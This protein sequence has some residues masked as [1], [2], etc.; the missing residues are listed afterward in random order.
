VGAALA[1]GSLAHRGR[2][3][4]IPVRDLGVRRTVCLY[5]VAGRQRTAAANA[6]LKVLRALPWPVPA[7]A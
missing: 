4:A 2:L 6:A 1:P 5:G 7:A 3:A